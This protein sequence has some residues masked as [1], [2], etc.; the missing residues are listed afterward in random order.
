MQT[1]MLNPDFPLTTQKEVPPLLSRSE[2]TFSTSQY[3][4]NHISNC[5][6]YKLRIQFNNIIIY[7]VN[8]FLVPLIKLF[9]AVLLILA[10]TGKI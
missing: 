8:I 5:F 10:N 1:Y 4:Q 2:Q 6:E 7:V 3:P 9:I